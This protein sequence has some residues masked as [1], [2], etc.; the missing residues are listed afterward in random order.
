MKKYS[1]LLMML[2]SLNLFAQNDSLNS[3]LLNTAEIL[4]ASDTKLTIGGYGQ[5]DYNQTLSS[6]TYQNGNLD[7]HRLVMLF[8]YRF[9]SKTNFVTEI[10]FEHVKEVFIEQAFLNYKIND[11]LNFRG[12]LLL[13]PMGIINE[14]HEPPT[15]NGVERPNLDN[16]IVPT[17]WR[18]IGAGFTGRFND[19][20]L[21]YQ[22]Y[23]INGF[24]GY[25]GEANFSGAKGL[26]SGRQK[27]AESFMSSPGLSGKIDYYGIRRLK[28]GFATYLGNSNSTLYDGINKSDAELLLQAD[29]SVV[30]IKMIGADLRYNYKGFQLKGQYNFIDIEN[31]DQYNEFAG[32]D[33]GRN[34]SGY[35]GEIAYNV[36][37]PFNFKTELT[38]FIRYENYDTHYSVDPLIVKNEAYHLEEIIFG[39]GWKL[40]KGAVLKADYQVIKSK[41]DTEYRNQLNI[42]IGVMF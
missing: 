29:S 25:D 5:I 1:L 41:I 33:L 24:N 38:P 18:E 22:I 4:I 2:I 31:S 19:I 8:A 3:S 21:K 6:D 11:Y 14:Y 36:F 28:L 27:G 17:T 42:G 12:G 7:V 23:V 40:A 16:K 20:A 35:Y 30:G 9:N 10:E 13:I 26:R 34:L 15:F 39:V 37:R 32:S